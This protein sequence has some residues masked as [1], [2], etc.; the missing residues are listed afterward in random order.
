MGDS[1][2]SLTATTIS[3]AVN[4]ALDI[5]LVV[6][7]PFGIAGAAIAT[8][9]SQITMT[10]FIVI[11]S[12]GKH[13]LMRLSLKT[14]WF[15]KCVVFRGLELGTPPAVQFATLS[16]GNLILQ[17]FMNGFG[18]S[19]VLAI[20]TAYRVDS[21][22]LLPVTNLSAAI[23]TMTAQAAGAEDRYRLKQYALSRTALMGSV[24]VLS[25]IAIYLCGGWL[26]A[27]FGVSQEAL[28]IGQS[29]FQDVAIFYIFYGL[30]SG[31]R[32]PSKSLRGRSCYVGR[33]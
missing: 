14:Q 10:A 23:S 20:T 32:G 19:A 8:V 29:F 3:S 2:V 11:Y 31:L 15:D 18:T 28:I 27:L 21:I 33:Y 5:I 30:A 25:A 1:K 12:R 9:T 22:L 4:V 6:F 26:I 24:S 17:N 13:P 16:F 7:L